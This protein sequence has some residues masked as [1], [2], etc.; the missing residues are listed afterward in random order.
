LRYGHP[1]NRRLPDRIATHTLACEEDSR[2]AFFDG[3]HQEC[4]ADKNKRR[5]EDGAKPERIRYKP[6]RRLKTLPAWKAMW[7][8]WI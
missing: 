4:G 6:L 8:G 5:G 7:S 2:W 3:N 1:H